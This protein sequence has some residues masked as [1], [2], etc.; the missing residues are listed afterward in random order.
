MP[1][2][3]REFGHKDASFTLQRYGHMMTDA[4]PEVGFDY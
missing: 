2:V 4:I 1:I 3:A